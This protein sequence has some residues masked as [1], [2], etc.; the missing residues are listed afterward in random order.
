MVIKYRTIGDNI[1][2]IES[3]LKEDKTRLLESIKTMDR[4]LE[5]AEN[6]FYGL[7]DYRYA[8]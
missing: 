4:L 3:E 6:L 2:K 1:N 7:C 5:V 8:G